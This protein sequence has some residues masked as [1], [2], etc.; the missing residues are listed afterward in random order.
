M[1]P[2]RTAESTPLDQILR[3]WR[4][5]SHVLAAAAQVSVATVRRLARLED[6]ERVMLGDVVRVAHAVSALTGVRHSCLDIV[7]GLGVARAPTCEV[8]EMI[9]LGGPS[10]R[11]RPGRPQPGDPPGEPRS[12][13]PLALP[14]NAA[15]LAGH[16]PTPD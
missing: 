9:R 11:R 6:V 1:P 14:A 13:T 10:R 12:D 2:P 5:A 16:A 8:R 15:C 3:E 4:C 7:P